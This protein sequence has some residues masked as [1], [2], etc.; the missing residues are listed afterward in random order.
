MSYPIEPAS[1]VTAVDMYVDSELRDA[2][3]YSNR[4]PLDES[5]IYRLHVL[6][7]QIYATAWDDATRAAESRRSARRQRESE[8]AA[9]TEHGPESEAS[10]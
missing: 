6:A 1:I 9:S 7:A 2:G 3:R 4:R 8:H 10:A 5:G